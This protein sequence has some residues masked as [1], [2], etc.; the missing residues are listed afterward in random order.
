MTDTDQ[1]RLAVAVDYIRGRID[2]ALG[3]LE[4][5]GLAERSKLAELARFHL[6]AAMKKIDELARA[7][8]DGSVR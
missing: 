1:R 2:L 4:H 8:T 5:T 7:V 6:E 3:E